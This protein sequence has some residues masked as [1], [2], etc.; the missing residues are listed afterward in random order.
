[1]ANKKTKNIPAQKKKGFT[2]VRGKGGKRAGALSK[3][4]Q[5]FLELC[6]ENFQ[7]DPAKEFIGM[8]SKVKL[9]FEE[10]DVQ[11]NTPTRRAN[12]TPAE[13]AEYWHLYDKITDALKVFLKFSFPTLK[14]MDVSGDT[15]GTSIF[16][17]NIPAPVDIQRVD[18]DGKTIN[19]TPQK[20]APV[21]IEDKKE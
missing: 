15:G 4:A 17:I 9:R 19:I 14:S 1:M 6:K 18:S 2:G 21:G 3:K 8:Y 11:F 12:M 13:R 20:P 7:F 10:L 16:H 5:T